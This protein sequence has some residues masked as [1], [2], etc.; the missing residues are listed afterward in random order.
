[1]NRTHMC[2][3]CGAHARWVGMAMECRYGSQQRIVERTDTFYCPSCE[4]FWDVPIAECGPVEVSPAARRQRI[5]RGNR[6]Q[7]L[8]A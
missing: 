8:T 2:P 7:S 3:E 1:M 5:E 4:K 6:A